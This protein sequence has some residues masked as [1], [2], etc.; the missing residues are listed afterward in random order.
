MFFCYFYL[1]FFVFKAFSNFFYNFRLYNFHLFKY[2]SKMF[3]KQKN[4]KKTN[5]KNIKLDLSLILLF[6][7]NPKI[8][9]LAISN[10][11]CKTLVTSAYFCAKRSSLTHKVLSLV[12][13]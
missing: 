8:S 2:I 9:F 3:I 1:I 11:F 5:K 13:S 4:S 6:Y 12:T 7:F 10:S